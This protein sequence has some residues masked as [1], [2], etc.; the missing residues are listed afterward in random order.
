M[1]RRGDFVVEVD[2]RGGPRGTAGWAGSWLRQVY[3]VEKQGHMSDDPGWILEVE[4]LQDGVA[5]R[6]LQRKFLEGC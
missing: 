5:Q 3:G 4:L 1:G 6:G 2:S